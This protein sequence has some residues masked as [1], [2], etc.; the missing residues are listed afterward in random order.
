MNTLNFTHSQSEFAYFLFMLLLLF[1]LYSFLKEGK[2]IS[3]MIDQ[4]HELM[5]GGDEK[6]SDDL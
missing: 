4:E 1:I 2:K 5:F 6:K 3:K